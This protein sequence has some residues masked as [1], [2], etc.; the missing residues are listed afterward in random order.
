VVYFKQ[1]NKCPVSSGAG[2]RARI[3][4]SGGIRN[5]RRLTVDANVKRRR[6]N[7]EDYAIEM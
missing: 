4:E 1:D 7:Y 6:L 5:Q 3:L 2:C